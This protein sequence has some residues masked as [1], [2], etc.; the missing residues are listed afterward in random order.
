MP[1]P[2]YLQ[3]VHS[4][5]SLRATHVVSTVP[6]PILHTLIPDGGPSPP[7]VPHL[8]ENPMSTVQVVNLVFPCPPKDVHP[9]GF[10]YLIPR[11]P[12][13]YPNKSASPGILGAVF[14]SCSLHA[15]DLPLTED[16]Y[17]KATHTKLTVMTGGP[18]PLHP[19]PHTSSSS[20]SDDVLPP[21]I[22]SLL[23]ELEAQL[24]KKL[25][26]PV[27][28]RIW[29][30]ENCIPTLLPGHLVRMEEM[31]ATV[32]RRYATW[33]G[34]LAVVGAGVGGVSVG[35]CVEAGRRVGRAWA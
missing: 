24:G 34:R 30:N 1:W 22:S 2:T 25:P 3:I 9:E 28:W 17:N 27:Y 8:M 29:N 15:Q 7:T 19:L 4:H 6:L 26:E 23:C 13:G 10:G 21:F 31:R 16:Y 35:D 18:Y 14:D 32:E 12:T 11:P 20:A 5:G 33:E